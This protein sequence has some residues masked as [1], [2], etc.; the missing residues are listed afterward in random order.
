MA[1]Q[2][3]FDFTHVSSPQAYDKASYCRWSFNVT[4]MMLPPRREPNSPAKG[5][6]DSIWLALDWLA[7]SLCRCWIQCRR[8]YSMRSDG[9]RKNALDQHKLPDITRLI[10]GRPKGPFILQTR[11]IFFTLAIHTVLLL[12][13]SGPPTF[14]KR[15]IL[16]SFCY[17]YYSSSS[18]YCSI[19]FATRWLAAVA[20]AAASAVVSS[21]VYQYTLRRCRCACCARHPCL[22]LLQQHPG[23]D[24][25]GTMYCFCRGYSITT[26]VKEKDKGCQR[27]GEKKE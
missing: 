4:T 7:R 8:K 1:C 23:A 17:Y 2:I 5:T 24:G 11:Q 20:V 27:G 18:F 13:K 3:Y 21:L 15:V 16:A 25:R 6:G 14:S 9:Y 22:S 10:T 26:Q 12:L 19:L